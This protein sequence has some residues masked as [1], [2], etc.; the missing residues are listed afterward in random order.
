MAA[1]K[2]TIEAAVRDG[3]LVRWVGRKPDR[4]L[5]WTRGLRLRLFIMTG[6]LIWERRATLDEAVEYQRR[7]YPTMRLS[8]WNPDD[9]PVVGADRRRVRLVVRHMQLP[10][11]NGRTDVMDRYGAGYEAHMAR[12]AQRAA[13]LLPLWDDG[14]AAEPDPPEPPVVC[15]GCAVVFPGQRRGLAASGWAKRRNVATASTSTSRFDYLCGRCLDEHG[16]GDE[17]A[18]SWRPGRPRLASA[19]GIRVVRVADLTGQT[20]RVQ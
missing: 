12:L 14:P 3:C 20:G 16:W 10:N 6:T 1:E 5:E 7:H 15:M 8:V 13:A 19:S 2:R 9:Y 17:V 18:R 11:P 4:T